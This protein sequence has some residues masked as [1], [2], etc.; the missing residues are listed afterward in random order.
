M[1]V[2]KLRELIKDLDDSTPV[3]LNDDIARIYFV[4]N[5][6]QCIELWRDNNEEVWFDEQFEDETQEKVIV[7]CSI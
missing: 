3:V 7:I 4:P 6:V 5:T 1:N 2:G